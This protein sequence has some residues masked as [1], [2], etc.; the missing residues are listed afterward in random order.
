MRLPDIRLSSALAIAT[1][2]LAGA[3][4]AVALTPRLS[5]VESAP[6]LDSTIPRQF[7]DWKE[8]SSSLVQVDLATRREGESSTDQPY[9]ET[10]MRTYRNTRGEV[11]QLA[12]AY[13][14]QQRQE[15][16]VH[17]P[18]LCYV[19]QGFKILALEPLRFDGVAHAAAPVD[20]KR[21][22]AGGRGGMEAV[23]YWIRIGDLYSESAWETRGYLLREGMAGRV[24]DGILVRASRPVSSAAEARQA[25]PAL[26]QFLGDLVRAAPPASVQLLVR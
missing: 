2:M 26:E 17:R 10:V 13:G 23:S 25:W 1:V 22:L 18:D 7:G 24:P 21:M 9:D 8:V 19:A 16:K 15:V 11:V 12:L 20:G 4:A 5:V 14:R 6:S 3:A